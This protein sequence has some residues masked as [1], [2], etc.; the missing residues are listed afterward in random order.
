[1]KT[2]TGMLIGAD[3]IGKVVW[4]EGQRKFLMVSTNTDSKT[5]GL[6]TSPDGKTYTLYPETL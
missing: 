2:T 3:A 6:W 4:S 5:N 1:M